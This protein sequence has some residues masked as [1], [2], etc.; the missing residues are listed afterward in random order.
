MQSNVKDETPMNYAEIQELLHIQMTQIGTLPK[1][2]SICF[3]WMLEESCFQY[4]HTFQDVR[5][6]GEVT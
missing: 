1:T 2:A 4:S 6:L 5:Q 3:I